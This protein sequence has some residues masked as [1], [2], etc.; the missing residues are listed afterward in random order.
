MSDITEP[1]ADSAAIAWLEA[2]GCTVVHGPKFV[3]V[4]PATGHR[5]EEHQLVRRPI[6]LSS[7]LAL[8][9]QPPKMEAV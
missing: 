1:T 9:S 2:F 5:A 3:G 4:K 6:G 8:Q 7:P